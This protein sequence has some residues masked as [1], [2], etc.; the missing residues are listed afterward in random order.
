[1]PK[2]LH[3]K[4]TRSLLKLRQKQDTGRVT[5]MEII[6]GFLLSMGVPSAITGFCFWMIERK[7]KRREDEERADR[8]ERQ[9]EFDKKEAAREKSEL[10]IIKSIQ[11]AIALGEA[12]ANAVARI[13]D[14]K[15]NGDMHA[16]LEYATKVKHE[17]KAFLTEQAISHLT[18]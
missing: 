18:E 11:A 15:C 2:L 3:T 13:P 9:K 14:A 12:T 1:M 10:Y 5:P 7:I 17:Q 6:A 16:A 8:L 4:W